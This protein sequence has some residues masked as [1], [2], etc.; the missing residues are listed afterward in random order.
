MK[1]T[2]Y[3]HAHEFS[4]YG[5]DQCASHAAMAAAMVTAT[6]AVMATERFVVVAVEYEN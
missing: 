5:F 1:S 2:A 6:G 3:T 4:F